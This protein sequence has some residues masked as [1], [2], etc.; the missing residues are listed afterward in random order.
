MIA[1]GKHGLKAHIPIRTHQF[2]KKHSEGH[3][4]GQL[5]ADM[6]DCYEALPKMARQMEAQTNLLQQVLERLEDHDAH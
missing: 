1:K 4:I 3:G 2:L 6:A 5:I